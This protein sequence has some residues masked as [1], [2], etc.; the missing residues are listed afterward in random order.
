MSENQK[1]ES[2]CYT[3]SAKQQEEIVKIRRKYEVQKENQMDQLRRLDES[4][5]KKAALWPIVIGVIGTLLL[6][7]GMSLIMTELNVMFH[8]TWNQALL[9]GIVIGV[10]GLICICAAYPLYVT[11]LKKERVKIA[12]EV[13]RLS[14]ELL[15]KS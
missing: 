4:A 15:H 9:T 3:Y 14:D 1:N 7:T 6:G 12:D 2:F 13:L 11:T 8:M 5:E 10:A